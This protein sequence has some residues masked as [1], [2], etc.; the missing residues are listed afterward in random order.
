MHSLF[1]TLLGLALLAGSG[2]TGASV[3]G[4]WQRLDS[5]IRNLSDRFQ[6]ASP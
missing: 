6:A 2:W 3:P 5:R 4:Q 1:Q